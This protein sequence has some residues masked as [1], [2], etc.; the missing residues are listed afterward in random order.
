MQEPLQNHNEGV[1]ENA[2]PSLEESFKVLLPGGRIYF[3][4][5]KEVQAGLQIIDLSQVPY[6]AIALYITG[7]PYLALKEPAM[8]LFKECSIPTLEKLIAI[9]RE[10]YPADVLILEKALKAKKNYSE[11]KNSEK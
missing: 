9:K 5:E 10:K 3:T 7:F 1:Q 11:R 2:K 8:E 6:N 4:G